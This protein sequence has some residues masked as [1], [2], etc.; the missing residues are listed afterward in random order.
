MAKIK[1]INARQILNG[2]GE[3]TIE[4]TVILN[5]GRFG[6]ASIPAAGFAGNYEAMELYD[7][8]PEKY[9]GKGVKKAISNITDT[10]APMLIDMEA[11]KQQEIDKKMIELDGTAN[12]GRLGANAILSVSIAVCKAAAQ[13]SLLPTYLYLREYI[14]KENQVLKIPTPIFSV[15]EGNNFDGADFKDFAI[16]MT[17]SQTFSI[18]LNMISKIY[19]SLKNL[20]QTNN[21]STLTSEMGGFSPALDSNEHALNLITQSIESANL[22]LGFDLFLALDANSETFFKD[23]KYKIKDRASSLSSNELSSYYMDICKRFNIL[24]VED[25]F[26]EEDLDGWINFTASSSSQ[27]LIVGDNLTATN[28]YRLQTA[29]EKKAIT[30]ITIKPLQVGTVIESLAVV[31]VARESG[32]KIVTSSRSGETNDDF[33]ADFAVAVSSDYIKLGGVTRGE[34]VSKYNRLLDIENHLKSF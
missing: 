11:T 27:A 5:D 16:L 18:G 20:L 9:Q 13:S 14:R 3:P 30:G 12:K 29:L 22:R 25:P 1:T 2:K 21:L 28:P 34:M 8:D 7:H 24:Y 32:L 17:S 15:L 26:S 31:E 33:I 19:N 23:Q 6:S 4:T 10:I